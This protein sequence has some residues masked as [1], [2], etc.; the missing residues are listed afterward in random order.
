VVDQHGQRT[1]PPFATATVARLYM[2]Q[3][4]LE[5][6]ERLYQQLLKQ[7]PRESALIEGLAEVR[8]RIELTAAPATGDRVNLEAGEGGAVICR[9]CVTSEGLARARL[10]LEGDGDLILQVVG[11]P[12]AKDAEG[13]A[14]PL[15][16]DQGFEG[17]T[18]L[19]PPHGAT[20]IA[21]AVGLRSAAGRFVAAAHCPAMTLTCPPPPKEKN[22]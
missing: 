21:A 6:S 7:R 16:T 1:A 11:F 15:D 5:Q 9:W 12:A 13:S 19:V 20:M 2:E 3:G 8:R 18:S 10:V 22:P 14:I 4:K 17:S